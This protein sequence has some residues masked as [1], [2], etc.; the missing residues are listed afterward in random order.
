MALVLSETDYKRVTIFTK[1]T[2][3]FLVAAS[4]I[5]LVDRGNVVAFLI[6]LVVGSLVAL[7]PVPMTVMRPDTY[8]DDDD[9]MLTVNE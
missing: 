8:P 1:I 9:G 2:G 3:I 7:A 5:M 4:T 6:L